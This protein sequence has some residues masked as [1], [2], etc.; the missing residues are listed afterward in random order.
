MSDREHHLLITMHHII[1]DDSSIQF[2]LKE[3][4]LVYEEFFLHLNI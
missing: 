2:F 3:L 4:S 1:S